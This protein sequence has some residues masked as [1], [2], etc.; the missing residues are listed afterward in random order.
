MKDLINVTDNAIR[1]FGKDSELAIAILTVRQMI[2]DSTRSLFPDR[3]P[4][5][6]AITNLCQFLASFV[7]TVPDDQNSDEDLIAAQSVQFQFRVSI[8]I[9]PSQFDPIDLIE[10]KSMILRLPTDEDLVNLVN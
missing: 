5:L 3:S 4:K 6:A 8:P 1:Y 2:V 9:R 10:L 7:P